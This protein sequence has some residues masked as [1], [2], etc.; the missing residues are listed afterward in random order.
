M[1]IVHLVPLALAVTVTVTSAAF[2]DSPQDKKG[3]PA[4]SSGKKTTPP[5]PAKGSKDTGKTTNKDP[6][7]K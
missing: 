2:A 4:S 1:K 7:A 3:A 6:A 5:P